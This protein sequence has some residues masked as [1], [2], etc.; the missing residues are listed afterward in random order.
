M[1]NNGGLTCARCG[2]K[3]S[4]TSDGMCGQCLAYHERPVL[5]MLMNL[6]SERWVLLLVIAV[7]LWEL[8]NKT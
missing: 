4:Q 8:W 1:W 2:R 5:T 6:V 7:V 3:V